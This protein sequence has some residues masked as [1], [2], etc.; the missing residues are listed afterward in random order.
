M[1]SIVRSLLGTMLLSVLSLLS[2][3]QCISTFPYNEDFEGL[4]KFNSSSSCNTSVPGDTTGGW[5]QDQND[6]GEWR[7]DT[8]G[9]P[10]IGTGPGATDT[11]SGSGTGK[12]Y[13]PGTTSGRYFYIEAQE[14]NGGNDIDN[15]CVQSQS[16]LISPCFDFSGSKYYRLKFAYHM[17][18]NGMGNLHIDVYDGSYWI[19]DYYIIRGNHGPQWNTATVPLAAFN[20]SGIKIR[21]RFSMGWSI[22]SDCA[23][24]DVKIEAYTPDSYDATVADAWFTPNDYAYIPKSQ[25]QEIKIHARIRNN[26][27]DSVSGAKVSGGPGWSGSVNFGGMSGSSV[28]LDSSGT[29]LKLGNLNG[30][31]V[32]L[33]A[34]INEKDANRNND[35]LRL[36]TNWSDT[37]YARDDSMYTGG[38][39]FN[40]ATNVSI[41]QMYEIFNQSVL[42]T[43]S[44]F[45][46]VTVTKGDSVRV[47][48][49]EFN[50][51]PGNLIAW[52]KN[53]VL[54]GN[55][56]W[57]TAEF[58]CPQ[59][60][61]PG[62][63]FIAVEQLNP[64]NMQLGYLM[65]K[66]FKP[67]M[68][69]YNGGASWTD[70]NA[71]GFKATVLL[72]MNLGKVRR[73][74]I[75][76][77]GLM[78]T[79]CQGQKMTLRG[80]G[81]TKYTWEPAPAFVNPTGLYSQFSTDTT[82]TVTVTGWDACDITNT[83]SKEIYVKRVPNASVTPDTTICLGDQI[84]LQAKTGNSYTW[85]NGPSDKDYVVTP[86]KSSNYS[87]TV[88]SS[89]GCSKTYNIAIQTS[90]P[91]MMLIPDTVTCEG[92]PITLYASGANS[93]EW[94]NGVKSDKTTVSP[95]S[96]RYY[97]V[98]GTNTL[99]C[100]GK[101]SVEVL[102]DP[103]PQTTVSNDT[104]ICFGQRVRLLVRGGVKNS[105]Q[106]GPSDSV[107]QF[108]PLFEKKYVAQSYGVNGCIRYDTVTVGV[109]LIPK[110]TVREDTTICEGT[111][112]D[113][114]AHCTDDVDFLWST[115]ETDSAITVS[116]VEETVYKVSAENTTGCSNEDSV[117][118][119]VSPLPVAGLELTQTGQQVTLLNTSKNADS[120]K[121]DFGDS[122]S[123]TESS[124][125]HTYTATD[126]YTITLTSTNECGS[127]DTS[128]TVH[129]VVEG[130]DEL[131]ND[132]RMQAHPNPTDG[133]ITISFESSQFGPVHVMLV[134]MTGH[135][136]V[137]Y[138]VV[139]SS[140]EFSKTIDLSEFAA[141]VYLLHVG[142][143][144]SESVVRI[145]LTR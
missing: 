131:R 122:K 57:S 64:N 69:F 16:G 85:K 29:K 89:N 93:Y 86:T 109:S 53:V 116:P 124:V 94:D 1:K 35:T 18:G 102:V 71:T 110:V 137:T 115:G 24:D 73:P 120:Y 36:R 104:V 82:V 127:D 66:Y 11:S 60:L 141:G 13:N 6:A 145:R 78:D 27:S 134:D 42:T 14:T 19:N 26:G 39:G 103:A 8:A 68:T 100:Q 112:V 91:Q 63:Y 128:V 41:G 108:L 21:F 34:S 105:W 139:K 123:S 101:D 113:L 67:G 48:L 32:N 47:G 96:S 51:T 133:Q 23:L 9:T 144:G 43:V 125:V 22:R 118:I 99:G 97:V 135:E 132:L 130:V 44:F 52:S 88:D 25:G 117:R 126:D 55:N 92:A 59:T 142:Q 95:A 114:V 38:V 30:P 80:K 4:S 12:D 140:R 37:I 84:R 62:K 17:F 2:Y 3:G 74:D 40:G 81:G 72:R 143:D 58:E 28:K 111:S 87:V 121:W 77:T 10:S 98:T 75:S 65:K 129:V 79:I 76:I 15:A 45:N 7:A 70:L 49:Y 119:G 5:T 61:K 20:S 136:L 56:T 46:E 107:W 31:N 33:I 138:D 90:T 54:Q 50:T 106:N 83:Y